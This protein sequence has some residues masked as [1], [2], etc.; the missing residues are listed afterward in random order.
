VLRVVKD[1]EIR[2]LVRDM[3]AAN[4]LWGAPR[5]HGELRILGFDVSERTVSRLMTRR[6]SPAVTDVVDVPDQSFSV[7]RV[8]R[9]LHGSDADR[10][11]SVSS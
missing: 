8:D 6:E 10:S 1:P 3:A 7:R 4:P 2:T 11:G 9:F 5:I